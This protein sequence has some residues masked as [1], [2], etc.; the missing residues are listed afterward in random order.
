MT[1]NSFIARWKGHCYCPTSPPSSRGVSAAQGD[2]SR[3]K[4]P[5]NTFCFVFLSFLPLL[6]VQWW[7]YEKEK[8]CS[9]GISVY[10][11]HPGIDTR[12]LQ[13]PRECFEVQ[14]EERHLF[15]FS[16][17]NNCSTHWH[18]TPRRMTGLDSVNM[19][20]G[21]GHKILISNDTAGGRTP[22]TQWYLTDSSSTGRCW[23]LC[24]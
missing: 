22:G 13:R 24:I 16:C 15:S 3:R 5:L 12:W 17:C 19:T 10:L 9:N 18:L 8:L 20:I 14:L 6:F 2:Y 4:N 11:L 23:Y 7:T 21:R 1:W